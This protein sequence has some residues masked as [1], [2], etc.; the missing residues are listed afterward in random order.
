MLNIN[1]QGILKDLKDIKAQLN[2]VNIIYK[3]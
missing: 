1:E 2:T 3:F